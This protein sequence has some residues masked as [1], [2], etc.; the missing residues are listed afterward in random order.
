MVLSRP[1][2]KSHVRVDWRVAKFLTSHRYG[3]SEKKQSLDSKVRMIS[4]AIKNGGRL[5][6]T[7]LKANDTKSKRI[8][9]PLE[10]GEMEYSGRPFLGVRAIC[11]LRGEERV[12]SVKKIL[13]MEV[14]E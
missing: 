3:E 6:I 5:A 9:E 14:E 4:A 8:I 1:L 2:K 12:F 13:E 11:D 10:V 7:Y